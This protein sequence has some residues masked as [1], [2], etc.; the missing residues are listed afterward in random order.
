ML[1]LVKAI[2]KDMV[3]TAR[4]LSERH[5]RLDEVSATRESGAKDV[6][7]EEMAEAYRAVNS[8][9]KRLHAY[10]EELNALGV[11]VKGVLDGLVDFPTLNGDRIVYLC[12]KLNEPEVLFW[13]EID[14]GFAGRR[15]LTDGFSES[16]VKTV[17]LDLNEKS[18]E[19]RQENLKSRTSSGGHI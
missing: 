9:T 3:E 1:P 18:D 5:E 10:V 4:S 17:S 15:S 12:W 7:S 14:S 11:E 13:H 19:D 2:A 8:D 6:Y 16:S